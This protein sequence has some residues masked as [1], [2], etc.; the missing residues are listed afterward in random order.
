M[1]WPTSWAAIT[2]ADTP[3]KLLYLAVQLMYITQ[4]PQKH[5]AVYF[6]LVRDLLAAM[7]SSIPAIQEINNHI[8]SGDYY[9]A[10]KESKKLIAYE[11]QLLDQARGLNTE[12]DINSAAA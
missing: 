7:P 11:K 3:A 5:H 4:D 8:L 10:L 6:D 9:K 12:S 2:I 1:A